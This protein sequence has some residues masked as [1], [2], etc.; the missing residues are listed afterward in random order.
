MI[1]AYEHLKVDSKVN[2]IRINRIQMNNTLNQHASLTLEL[3]LDSEDKSV[4]RLTATDEVCLIDTQSDTLLFSG[5]IGSSELIFD[6]SYKYLILT[7]VSGSSLLDYEKNSRTFQGMT[8]DEIL[9]E[10]FLPY[11]TKA[12]HNLSISETAFEVQYNETDYEFVR[13]LA[14]KHSLVVMPHI[15]DSKAKL[16]IDIKNK[17]KGLALETEDFSRYDFSESPETYEESYYS[18]KS[19]EHLDVGDTVTFQG[20]TLVVTEV[21]GLL[22]DGL[23]LFNYKAMPKYYVRKK[24]YEHSYFAGTGL[25]ATVLAVENR[26]I[27]VQFDIDQNQDINRAEWIPYGPVGCNGWYTMP[28]VGTKVMIKFENELASSAIGISMKRIGHDDIEPMSSS[29]N[30]AFTIKEGSHL[31]MTPG[32]VSL[33][34]DYTS[35]T[36][37]DTIKVSSNDSLTLSADN[38]MNIGQTVTE[39]IDSSGALALS[40][41]ETKNIRIKATELL[42]MVVLSKGTGLEMDEET[43]FNSLG[44]TN[45]VGSDKVA[46]STIAVNN[47]MSALDDGQEEEAAVETEAKEEK[48]GFWNNFGK[49]AAIAVATVAVAAVAIVAAPVVATAIVGAAAST[50]VTGIATGVVAGAAMGCAA[51]VGMTAAMDVMDNGEISK[52]ASEYFKAAVKGTITGGLAGGIGAGVSGLHVVARIGI[53]GGSDFVIDIGEQLISSGF[54]LSEI[55]LGEAAKN[56]A[57][58]IVIGEAAGHYAEPIMR[59]IKSSAL[60]FHQNIAEPF[61]DLMADSASKFGKKVI[62]ALDD[63]ARVMNPNGGLQPAMAGVNLKG[64]DVGNSFKEFDGIKNKAI[65]YFK[66]NDVNNDF[67]GMLRGSEVKLPDVKTTEI[68][69]VKRDPDEAKKLRNAFN[70]TEKKKF[71]NSLL[72]DKD[73]LLQAGL[74]KAD[75][76]RIENGLNPKGWQVHHKLPLDDGGT[77]SLDNFV[78]I[79]NEPY[80]KTITNFQNSFAQKFKVG[81]INKVYWP[82]PDGKIYPPVSK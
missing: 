25:E 39:Y 42:S 4:E 22:K 12:Y 80:H 21:N 76:A 54:K 5:I 44:Q 70:S 33:A 71:L 30:K 2:Y 65:N 57:I 11:G 47:D 56:A 9:D 43:V 16:Y 1:V 36:L 20:H 49:I 66:N 3:I 79:K 51:S 75:I 62:G 13:R 23:M 55:N 74:T 61:N 29:S 8:F 14:S 32:Q 73:K 26:Q 82:I 77:N 64:Y 63:V 18:F 19:L 17:D 72:E 45:L 37:G 69:Y 41:K 6:N 27:K 34:N 35:I 48:G 60:K 38:E 52:D 40:V 81:E 7:V 59:N 28:A 67:S 10:V 58:G 15:K 46:Y 68:N 50:A 78:L 53:E 31:S 24:P